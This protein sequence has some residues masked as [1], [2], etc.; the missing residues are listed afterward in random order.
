MTHD[1][2]NIST[3]DDFYIKGLLDALRRFNAKERFYLVG[4]FLGNAKFTPNKVRLAELEDKLDITPKGTFVEAA[5]NNI[6][7]AM[8]YHLDWL[9]G[10]LELAFSPSAGGSRKDNPDRVTGT[11]EDIDLLIAFDTPN[12]LKHYHIVLI[13]AKGITTFSNSQM[14]SKM[15][16]LNDIFFVGGGKPRFNNLE[17]HLVLAEP[18]RQ[19]PKLIL[20]GKPWNPKYFDLPG[21]EKKKLL[22]ITL[23][24]DFGTPKSVSNWKIEKR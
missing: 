7:C 1:N 4:H 24:D 13:E 18:H 6:F 17:V 3:K 8:D 19:H 2:N 10:A 23:T 15:K 14:N 12:H 9:N 16:R 20:P 5:E 21:P 11:Q 22:K